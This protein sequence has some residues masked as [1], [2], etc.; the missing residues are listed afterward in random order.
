M[1]TV[2]YFSGSAEHLA[3]VHKSFAGGPGFTDFGKCPDVRHSER[4]DRRFRPCRREFLF[5]RSKMMRF[6]VSAVVSCSIRRA[7]A[8]SILSAS[9]SAKSCESP[10]VHFFPAC[11]PGCTDC[12]DLLRSPNKFCR[13]FL[14]ST[15][16]TVV[17]R[18]LWKFGPLFLRRP[19]SA[20]AASA[21]AHAKSPALP[22]F[23][24]VL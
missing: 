22:V 2:E 13:R 14:F 21:L 24:V 17:R 23:F 18:W 15:L 4:N 10:V 19:S 16:R 12:A 5:C 1:S 6:I 7:P 11:T 3:G 8:R 9:W 20:P